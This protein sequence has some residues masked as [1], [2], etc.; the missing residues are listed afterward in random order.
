MDELTD[1]QRVNTP[2][3]PT[4][5][6]VIYITKNYR[7]TFKCMKIHRCLFSLVDCLSQTE[8]IIKELIPI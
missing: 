1:H 4:I 6:V 3:V 8:T 7:C 2:S 5:M